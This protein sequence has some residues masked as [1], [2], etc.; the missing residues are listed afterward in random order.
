M[1]LNLAGKTVVITG[2]GSNIG[3]AISFRFAEERAN[4]VLAD[5]DANQANKVADQI[6]K[7]GGE[8]LVIQTDVTDNNQVVNM[9]K[10]ATD[11]LDRWISW[12]I[13]SVAALW[14]SS[15]SGRQGKNGR[16]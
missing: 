5:Y 13:M 11:S 7:N 14:I 16:T 2:G 6:K 1:D 10:E 9:V 8:A 4:V 15:L 12:S 3:R